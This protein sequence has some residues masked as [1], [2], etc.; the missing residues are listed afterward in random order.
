MNF[1]ETVL[2]ILESSWYG[3]KKSS[4]TYKW[5]K[6][7]TRVSLS[8]VLILIIAVWRGNNE[9]KRR[10]CSPHWS[11]SLPSGPSGK[12]DVLQRPGHGWGQ[13]SWTRGVSGSYRC[14]GNG[15]IGT[16]LDYSSK[17]TIIYW[18]QKDTVKY[19]Y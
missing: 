19:K 8:R 5:R 2:L 7:T 10:I 16:A 3:S 12:S 11:V 13:I 14:L 1:V 4:Y 9:R 18:N 17:I 6:N 15:R